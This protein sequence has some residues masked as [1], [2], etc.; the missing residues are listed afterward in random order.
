MTPGQLRMFV[1]ID[2][3]I[4][5]HVINEYYMLKDPVWAKAHPGDRGMLCIACVER[6]L[7]RLLKHGD[8]APYPINYGVFLKSPLLAHRFNRFRRN[9]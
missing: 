5:T 6:R 2:C 3:K 1:C 7:G 9:K 4:N 8:F